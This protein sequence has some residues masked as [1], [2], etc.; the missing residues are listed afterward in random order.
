MKRAVR[1]VIRLGASGFLLVG[2]MEIGLEFMQHR[3]HG[4]PYG[5]WRLILGLALVLAGIVL[6]ALSRRLAERITDD[7]DE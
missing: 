1:S 7:F 6:L 2:A 4:A 5:G 3:L